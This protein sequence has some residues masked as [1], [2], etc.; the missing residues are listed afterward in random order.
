[1]LT[2]ATYSRTGPRVQKWCA[3]QLIGLSL[4]C[5]CLL[6]IHGCTFVRISIGNVP[7]LFRRPSLAHKLN[8]TDVPPGTRLS[9]TWIGHATVLLQ[10]DDVFILT[11]PVLTN[12]IGGASKR[13]IET[14]MDLQSIPPLDAVLISHRHMDHLSPASLTLLAGRIRT[15]VVPPRV[16]PDLP[17]E[18]YTVTELSDWQSSDVKGLKIPAV[19]VI[20]DGG[21][22]IGDMTSHPKSFRGY[23]I[24]YH[25]MTV[26][27]PGDTAFR[28]DIFFEVA[29]RIGAVDLA[30]MPICPIAPEAAIA[31]YSDFLKIVIYHNCGGERMVN[32]ID[33][34]ASSMFGD[35]PRQELLDFHYRILD[36][37]ERSLAEIS[38]AG[39]SVDY[40]Y[41]ETKRA[42]DGLQ[43][44][45]TLLW[46][47]IDVDIP[48]NPANRNCTRE[49]TREAVLAAWSARRFLYQWR[50][51]K[52]GT[53]GAMYDAR[54]EAYSGADCE[55]AAA[56]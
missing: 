56:G 20:H 24:Q 19:P 26:Y 53:R 30:V 2:Q 36:Y 38:Q 5:S 47:G 6:L 37:K 18:R 55:P 16:T 4:L 11:D 32:Y 48:T 33:N 46:P 39:F 42:R 50:R 23:V 49:G 35:V 41:R 28:P 15:V 45:K 52:T 29:K 40:V 17:K 34:V 25:D 3:L 8:R 7:I 13:L 44:T 10:M 43:G 22:T 51:D 31:P 14:G 12:T 1:L 9:A 54:Q 21:R 27:Y